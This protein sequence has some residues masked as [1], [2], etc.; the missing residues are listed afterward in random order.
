MNQETLM[1]YQNQMLVLDGLC[2]SHDLNREWS[3]GDTGPLLEIHAEGGMVM[4]QFEGQYCHVTYNAINGAF[5]LQHPVQSLHDIAYL[6]GLGMMWLK[7][8]TDGF[9]IRR[10]AATVME[11][12]KRGNC[13]EL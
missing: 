12:R 4:C 13:G 11:L 7:S 5:E 10:Q 9:T 6:I 1:Q 3:D 8:H 2:M